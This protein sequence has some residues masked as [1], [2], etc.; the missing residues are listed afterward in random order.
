MLASLDS[1]NLTEELKGLDLKI[2]LSEVSYY[3]DSANKI[4]VALIQTSQN[5]GN[6]DLNAIEKEAQS[7]NS[8]ETDNKALENLLEDLTL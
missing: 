7:L 6:L 8:A 2:K 5:A 4:G 1:D 3:E